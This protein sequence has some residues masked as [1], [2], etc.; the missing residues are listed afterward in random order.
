[1]DATAHANLAQQYGVRGYP[2]IK[3]FP[4]G[5]KSTPQD[6]TG[7]RQAEGIVDFALQGLEAAGAPVAIRQITS[8]GVFDSACSGVSAKLCALVFLPHILDSGA[9]GRNA[10]LA[11][12]QDIAK[13]LRKMPLSF[14]WVEAGA[15]PALESALT[16]SGNFPTVA[17][18][19][20]EKGV[21]AVMKVSWSAKNIQAFLQ[22]SLSGSEKVSALATIPKIDTVAEWDGKDAVLEA[23]EIPL[24]QLFGDDL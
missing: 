13:S 9:A 7:P 1:M 3:V 4:A 19:S 10:Y 17:V 15:Q 24:D 22:G 2:T 16:I 6:Y 8:Q 5:P 12:F 21:F 14:V 23:E 18:L 20:Q 11:L